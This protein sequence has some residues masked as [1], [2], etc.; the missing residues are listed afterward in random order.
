MSPIQDESPAFRLALLKSERLRIVILLVAMGLALL[1]RLIRTLVAWNPENASALLWL[2]LIAGILVV[3]DAIVHSV[4]R[5]AIAAWKRRACRSASRP[6]FF[7]SRLGASHSPAAI[8]WCSPPT[9]FLNGPI[10]PR[11]CMVVS[12]WKTVSGLS[13]INPQQKSSRFSTRMYFA[14]REEL[15]EGRPYRDCDQADLDFGGADV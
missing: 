9:V 5:A 4:I 8:S 14:L 1:D 2:V 10:H 12:A 6:I 11:S 7:P 15:A 13:V 3:V